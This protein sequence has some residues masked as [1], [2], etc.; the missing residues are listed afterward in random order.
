ME[1]TSQ[2]VCCD[3]KDKITNIKTSIHCTG[4][5]SWFCYKCETAFNGEVGLGSGKIPYT[6]GANGETVYSGG[7][8]CE[9][10]N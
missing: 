4:C 3:C 10:C 7:K 8:W 5:N 9:Y 6:I 1:K 2:N